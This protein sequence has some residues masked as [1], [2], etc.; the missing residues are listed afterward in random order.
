MLRAVLCCAAGPASAL[1]HPPLLCATALA[2]YRE[3]CVRRPVLLPSPRS[4]CT[5]H[6]ADCFE[7]ELLAV[8]FHCHTLWSSHSDRKGVPNSLRLGLSQLGVH[9]TFDMNE[10]EYAV[11]SFEQ[12]PAAVRLLETAGIH[13]GAG[14]NSMRLFEQRLARESMN[15]PGERGNALLAGSAR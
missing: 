15:L 4:S 10:N 12:K 7:L 9:Y 3:I 8:R 2:T 11:A 6:P 14:S 13:G 1:T 5:F